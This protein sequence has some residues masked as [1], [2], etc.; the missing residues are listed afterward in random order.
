MQR[1]W[2]K[3]AAHQRLFSARRTTVDFLARRSNAEAAVPLPAYGF[4]DREKVARR[5]RAPPR[6]RSY[7]PPRQRQSTGADEFPSSFRYSARAARL[8][9]AGHS[10]LSDLW[11]LIGD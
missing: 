4:A 9:K 10:L 6:W 2:Q 3:V 8:S 7:P 5:A 11:P 1:A